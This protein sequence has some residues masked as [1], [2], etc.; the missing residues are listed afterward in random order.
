MT[1]TFQK[2]SPE[3]VRKNYLPYYRD[4]I[5]CFLILKD[6]IPAGAAPAGL[7][8]LI[9]R[10]IDPVT[11]VRQAE[12]F[13]TIF[14][15]FRYRVLG[16]GFFLSL[17]DHALKSGFDAVYTWTRLSS[18]Q[19][20]LDR[21]EPLGIHRLDVPPSWSLDSLDPAPMKVWFAKDTKRQSKKED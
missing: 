6:Q 11:R 18:W 16:K 13:L 21:F 8:G 3:S 14:P 15:A 1:I 19:K 10:G 5:T 2:L 4:D 20:L 12:A 9:D 17:F 7:Y